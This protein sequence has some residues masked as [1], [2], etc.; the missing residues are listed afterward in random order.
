[1]PASGKLRSRWTRHTTLSGPNRPSSAGCSRTERTKARPSGSIGLRLVSGWLSAC[2]A[3]ESL[4]LGA[5]HLHALPIGVLQ[6][7]ARS[8]D[9]VVQAEGAAEA[10]LSARRLAC[11]LYTSDA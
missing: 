4:H 9:R 8:G 1:M 6:S 7:S 5:Q 3:V 10:V 2:L 11:L